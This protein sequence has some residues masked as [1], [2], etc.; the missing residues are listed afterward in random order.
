MLASFI[1]KDGPEVTETRLKYRG[2]H[3][4]R[5]HEL[6]HQSR[7]VFA[8]PLTS[9]DNNVYGSLII[10]EFDTLEQAQKWIEADPYAQHQVYEEIIVKA[11]NQL[12]PKTL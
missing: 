1:C 12:L 9:D 2:E 5:L 8:G 3:R 4:T 7:I 11:T 10:A 6:N